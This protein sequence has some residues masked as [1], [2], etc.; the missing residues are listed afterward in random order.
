MAKTAQVTI[1]M[2]PE[3]SEQY[4]KA[5]KIT[6]RSRQTLMNEAA[7]AYM[8]MMLQGLAV[9]PDPRLKAFGEKMKVEPVG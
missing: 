2:T 3:L 5:A 8:S 1:R 4:S 9:T 7:T 6:G